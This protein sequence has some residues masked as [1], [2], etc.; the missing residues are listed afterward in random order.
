MSSPYTVQIHQSTK[1]PSISSSY[2]YS[3]D[4]HTTQVA[5]SGRNL[6]INH[7]KVSYEKDS[8]APK[9]SGAYTRI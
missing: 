4:K 9:Y 7:N 8:P 6:V 2:S 3:S 1:E 5:S